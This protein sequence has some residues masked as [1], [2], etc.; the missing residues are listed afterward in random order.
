MLSMAGKAG[1]ATVTTTQGGAKT[2]VIAAPKG[3]TG[4]TTTGQK[5]ISTVPKI[6]GQGNTQFIVVSP[7]TSL[8]QGV[9]HLQTQGIE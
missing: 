2:I 6:G 8:G 7:Q 9:T 1:Q 4:T 3:T 5:I